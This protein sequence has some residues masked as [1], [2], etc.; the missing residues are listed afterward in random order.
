[1]NR[2][3][4]NNALKP[5]ERFS[6]TA[7]E[8]FLHDFN[9]QIYWD[10]EDGF[11]FQKIHDQ[12]RHSNSLYVFTEKYPSNNVYDFIQNYSKQRFYDIGDFN[13][14]INNISELTI[15][16]PILQSFE[17]RLRIA[18]ENGRYT[19][20]IKIE[21]DNNYNGINHLSGQ[22]FEDYYNLL[23]NDKISTILGRIFLMDLGISR[24]NPFDTYK[25]YV[26]GFFVDKRYFEDTFISELGLTF[27]DLVA[28]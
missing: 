2:D 25:R 16:E 8:K 1:M 17:H 14:T 11:H 3:I 12:S 7:W 13:I 22:S 20:D 26:M 10:R 9:N 4:L 18:V 21:Y 23:R 19:E 6:V 24:T 5:S 28:I 27:E 15:V